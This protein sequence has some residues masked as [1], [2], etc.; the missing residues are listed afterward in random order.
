MFY[1]YFLILKKELMHFSNPLFLLDP[2]VLIYMIK[3]DISYWNRSDTIKRL[4]RVHVRAKSVFQLTGSDCYSW[5]LRASLKGSRQKQTST[6][7]KQTSWGSKTWQEE[8]VELFRVEESTESVA[9]C[10]EATAFSRRPQTDRDS[11]RSW[12]VVPTLHMNEN[13]ASCSPSDPDDHC[14]SDKKHQNTSWSS[15]LRA[16]TP[17]AELL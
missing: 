8:T 3:K 12:L 7:M 11:V 14:P 5:C 15:I 6:N 1:F 4:Q 17:A 10:N 9:Q 2:I 16:E 13:T